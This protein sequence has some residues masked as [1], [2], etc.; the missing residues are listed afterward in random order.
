MFIKKAIAYALAAYTV[1][2]FILVIYLSHQP[3]LLTAF[4]TPFSAAPIVA[5]PDFGAIKNTAERKA[6]FFNFFTPF[7][8][9]ENRALEAKRVPLLLIQKKL[10]SDQTLSKAELALIDK[11]AE[12]FD[13][14]DDDDA[15]DIRR[16]NELVQRVDIIP[17]ALVLAQAANESAWGRSRFAKQGNNYFGQWCFKKG[18]GLVPNQRSAN[19]GHEVRKFN[20]PAE[21]VSAYFYNINT[22]RAYAE[23]RKMRD[24]L[25]VQ[26]REPTGTLLA[27]GLEHYSERGEAY[28]EELRAMIRTNRLEQSL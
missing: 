7:I 21:S 8:D 19:A 28:I 22:H 18:C 17:S 10:R 14:P 1:C 20:S 16:V 25:R 3:T 13:L 12:D 4:T 15:T 9:A 24:Y 11:L 27:A 5:T 6:A 2:V 23:L 26:N